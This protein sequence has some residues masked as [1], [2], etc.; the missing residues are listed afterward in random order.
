MAAAVLRYALA[1][2]VGVALIVGL[3][4]L[5]RPFIFSFAAPRDDTNYAVIA[6]SE[7]GE[8]PLVRD[9]LLNTP[10]N[11]LGERRNGEHAEITVV[12]SRGPGGQFF[13]V[14]A[15]SS[16]RPCAVTVVGNQLQDCGGAAW[17]LAGDALAGAD[18]PLQRWAATVEQGAV[19]VDFTRPIG[20]GG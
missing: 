14:N 19:T 11:L 10:H 6:T 3:M 15:W 4:L 5:V 12:V 20:S 7:V 8:Q 1:A 13:V 17:T 18:A 9:L 2:I 16:A